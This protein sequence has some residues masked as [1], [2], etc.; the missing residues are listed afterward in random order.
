M[1]LFGTVAA[2]YA[3]YGAYNGGYGGYGHGGYGHG[4]YGG[5]HG[6][7]GG[8]HGHH[9]VDYYVSD[10]KKSYTLNKI[11]FLGSKEVQNFI[12]LK[13]IL[14]K[15]GKS[16]CLIMLIFFNLQAYPKY[17]YSYGVQVNTQLVLC[18]HF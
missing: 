5:H 7:H 18:F 10:L 13:T 8:H 16:S 4:G 15:T 11:E 12:F 2:G 6:H 9:H 3:G 1:A 14:F 17:K